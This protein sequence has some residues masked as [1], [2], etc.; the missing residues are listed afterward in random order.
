MELF[1]D[2]FLYLVENRGLYMQMERSAALFRPKLMVA[3]A[4]AY[5]RHYD[6][7]RMR[8]VR[9]DQ[10]F[11]SCLIQIKGNSTKKLFTVMQCCTC[12]S[13]KS[14][15][16]SMCELTVFIDCRFVTSKRLFCLQIWRTLV[17][18]LQLVLFHH[19]LTLLT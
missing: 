10:G 8:K 15:E 1:V 14:C 7:A 3:G 19:P 17:D 12:G 2:C 16:Y 11:H 13:F 4:S 5:A 9:G 6:Y 18:L